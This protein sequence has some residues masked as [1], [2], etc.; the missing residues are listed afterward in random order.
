MTFH[1]C[2]P[3]HHHPDKNTK[4]SIFSCIVFCANSALWTCSTLK[5]SVRLPK[6]VLLHLGVT[7]EANLASVTGWDFRESSLNGADSAG[8]AVAFALCTPF[9]C[10]E[11]GQDSWH[12][13]SPSVTMQE[14]WGWKPQS[15]LWFFQWSYTDVRDGLWRKLSTKEL[16]LLNCGVGEDSWESLGLQGDPPSPS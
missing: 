14:Q 11:L 1:T 4:R 10:V 3:C 9:S 2:L 13:C 12:P 8:R 15:R 5:L 16:M 6:K 7:K